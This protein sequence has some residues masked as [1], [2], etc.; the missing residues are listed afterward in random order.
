MDDRADQFFNEFFSIYKNLS[1]TAQITQPESKY[2]FCFSFFHAKLHINY[3][4]K[5]HECLRTDTQES[6]TKILNP[7]ELI[8]MLAI[9]KKEN[10]VKIFQCSF[11]VA[12]SSEKVTFPLILNRILLDPLE[13][14][15]RSAEVRD[16]GLNLISLLTEAMT[17]DRKDYIAILSSNLLPVMANHIDASAGAL[18][19]WHYYFNFMRLVVVCIDRS[20]E[21]S[22]DPLEK[23]QSNTLVTA[24]IITYKV[25]QKMSE[26]Y[27]AYKR[28]K[29][30]GLCY[31]Q[32]MSVILSL[33][34]EMLVAQV[35]E[36]RC[37]ENMWVLFKQS[38]QKEN[39]VFSVCLKIIRDI[40]RLNIPAYL[41][42]FGASF[43]EE[44][45]ER[46]LEANP[47]VRKTMQLFR[48]AHP[49]LVKEQ[50]EGQF[51]E[52]SQQDVSFGEPGTGASMQLEVTSSASHLIN[53]N[54][55]QILAPDRPEYPGSNGFHAEKPRA[56]PE[57][58]AE[59]EGSLGKRLPLPQA[60]GL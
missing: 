29:A 21:K 54:I 10:A 9:S 43:G 50:F 31:L 47:T 1:V 24:N 15:P 32:F 49:E 26:A 3:L 2:L 5:I 45:A 40:E 25:I 36:S 35:L 27:A 52:G 28:H 22:A 8:S 34:D 57:P 11:L 38:L 59:E 39:I 30:M 14:R 12:P 55:D 4:A 19:P 44:I 23:T 13:S 48:Q 42:H 37:L 33:E 18:P 7:M 16:C 56:R 20:F 6:R 51:S 17:Q 41:K 53:Q 46:R 58:P 60:D